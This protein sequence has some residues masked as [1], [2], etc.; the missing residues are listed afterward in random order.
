MRCMLG[1]MSCGRLLRL[2]LATSAVRDCEDRWWQL[3]ICSHNVA[4]FSLFCFPVTGSGKCNWQSI[5][6]H[7]FGKC[8]SPW[9]NIGTIRA[10][11]REAL[12]KKSPHPTQRAS[13]S[14]EPWGCCE[15]HMFLMSMQWWPVFNS[16]DCNKPNVLMFVPW[17]LF[18]YTLDIFRDL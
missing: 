13:E 9:M 18:L 4:R 15:W 10:N 6:M 1:T 7:T 3:H 8:A 17:Y 11:V 2:K 16:C 12:A 5:Q 14:S